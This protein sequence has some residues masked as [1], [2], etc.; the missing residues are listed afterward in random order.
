MF[1]R[2]AILLALYFCLIGAG[3]L[4][5]R[6]TLF[7][8]KMYTTSTGGP[9][10][11]TESFTIVSD[12]ACGSR[13]TFLL[14]VRN[15]AVGAS[16]PVSSAVI[17]VNGNAVFRENDFSGTAA[18]IERPV[19]LSAGTNRLD[20]QLKGGKAGS[21]FSLY[22]AKEIES[23]AFGPKDF[24]LASKQQRFVESFSS[25][26]TGNYVLEVRS[27]DSSALHRAQSVTIALNGTT[28][29]TDKEL[30]DSAGYLRKSV[31]LTATNSLTI[32][33]KGSPGD[34]TSIS[35]KRVLDESACG[36]AITIISPADRATVTAARIQ[37]SGSVVAGADVGVMVNGVPAAVDLTHAGTASDP[38]R[39][40]AE[41]TET[42]GPVTITATAFN[43]GGGAGTVARTITFAPGSDTVSLLASV[44]SGA[45]PLGVAFSVDAN[46]A[47]PVTSYEFDLDGDGFYETRSTEL[48]ASLSNTYAAPGTFQ[49][50]VRITTSA[51]QTFVATT[52]VVAQSFAAVDQLLRAIWNGFAGALAAGNVDA[53]LQLMTGPAQLRYRDRLLLIRSD[54]PAIAASVQKV[55]TKNIGARTAHY[56]VT[57]IEG[58]QTMG[59]HVYFVRD[60]NNVWRLEQ[61]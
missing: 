59:H 31:S 39:W 46:I 23:P 13:A 52:A 20:V 29:M 55:L 26:G 12:Q 9:Q 21:G 36:P 16:G 48:P 11:S 45:V 10:T 37:V 40:Y 27:G 22:I 1:R 33:M 3:G 56:L 60:K 50:A 6:T 25:S 17:T 51:G 49:P 14:G 32:D 53:A 4:Q 15:G 38:L 58:G 2:T 61:F 47:S 19:Q 28:V 54:L 41:L 18:T 43:A 44:N 8:P 35:V 30:T 7:G 42:P 5:A 57:R 24:I 34:L